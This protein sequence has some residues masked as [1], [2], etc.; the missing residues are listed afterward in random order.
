MAEEGFLGYDLTNHFASHSI[1]LCGEQEGD[2]NGG[3]EGG[4]SCGYSVEE[5][6]NTVQ[7]RVTEA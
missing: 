3:I 7:A 6:F 5:A 4:L 1:N 2:K